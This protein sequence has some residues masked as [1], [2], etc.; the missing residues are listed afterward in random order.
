MSEINGVIVIDKPPDVSSARVVALLKRILN[1]KKIGHTGTLDP[2]ATGVLVCCLNQATKLARFFLHGKK[3]Y[4]AV[5]RLG[6]ETDTQDATGTVIDTSP[7]VDVSEDR[8][9]HVFDPLQGVI[10]NADEK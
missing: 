2:F 5:M 4:H 10:D 7:V 6:I 8:L 1:V 9:Q 3:R